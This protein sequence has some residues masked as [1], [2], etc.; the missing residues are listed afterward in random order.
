MNWIDSSKKDSFL[1]SSERAS[2]NSF[3]PLESIR[4]EKISPIKIVDSGIKWLCLANEVVMLSLRV[5][6]CVYYSALIL[7]RCN[8]QMSY[9]LMDH[10]ANHFPFHV[11][12][13][14]GK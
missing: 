5:Q 12:Q 14:H 13:I 8:F 11:Q 3:V 7:L 6:A 1:A 2:I 10:N 9:N 4:R